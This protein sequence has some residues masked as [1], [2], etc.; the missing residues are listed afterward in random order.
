MSAFITPACCLDID[1]WSKNLFQRKLLAFCVCT[2]TLAAGINLPARSV[3]L[4]S[5]LKGPRDKKK[6]M[7]TASAQQIFGRAGRPQFDDRGYVFALA[8]EDD[9][10]IH[11]WR[12][13]YDSIPEDTK[14]PGLLKAK[15]QLK[16]KM[17]K[18]RSG[19]SYWTEQQFLQL[20]Q[21]E[22]A[23]L[24]SRGRLPWRLLAYLFGTTPQ[25]QPIRDLVGRRLLPP[26]GIEEAQRDLNRM[27]ITLWTAGYIELDPKPHAAEPRAMKAG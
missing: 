5:L 18:R 24:V 10:K 6:L 11:R 20:Q 9:V 2:E 13:K 8:H 4:P 3:V 22:S 19:E 27:L 17:P 25:V 23:D 15:K 1:G 12:E 14:D 26:K 21:A 16:K 7:E